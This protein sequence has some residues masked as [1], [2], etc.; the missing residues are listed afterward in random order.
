MYKVL[1]TVLTNC[2]FSY[3]LIGRYKVQ[4]IN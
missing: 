1:L 3:Q 2:V 4:V